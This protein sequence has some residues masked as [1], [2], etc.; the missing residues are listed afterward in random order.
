[1]EARYSNPDNDPRGDWTSGDLSARNYYGD[2]TYSITCPSGRIIPGPP[3]GTYW[4]I[5][6]E[7][8]HAWDKDGQIW[9]GE[10]GNNQ[11][12]LKRYKAKVKEGRVPQTI[13]S[14]TE[15]GHTQ[16]AKKEL[17][18][19]LDFE[20]SKDVFITPK[21]LE[22]IKK[23]VEIATN[24]DSIILDS[25]AGSGT[26]AQA[27]LAAND[28]DNGSRRFILVEFEDYANRLTAERIRR[29]IQG[30]SFSGKHCEELLREKITWTRFRNASEILQQ[31]NFIEATESKRF[32]VIKK[33]IKDGELVVVGEKSVSE[34]MDGLGGEFTFCTLGEPIDFDKMLTGEALPSF[35]ALGSALFHTATNRPFDASQ[36]D[37]N[38]LDMDGVGYLGA[39]ENLH[40]WLIYKPELDFLKSRDAALTLSKA[41][42]IKA[43]DPDGRHLVFAPARFVSQKLLNEARL[44]VEFAP[45][46]FALYRIERGS[47]P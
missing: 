39:S 35:E 3:P 26:T 9:W 25:F 12:R 27:V 33:T 15:V 1:M 47:Q 6:K 24:R 17:L 32:D 43:K 4:R 29:V 30:Y 11:P 28:S 40:I 37:T 8:F 13:W 23:V 21:P 7:K 14:Y 42:A 44:P 16:D 19:I 2:G 34:T 18:R 45:L 46:P 5:S 31:I 41:K 10:D 38:P 36:M 20:S 22:L